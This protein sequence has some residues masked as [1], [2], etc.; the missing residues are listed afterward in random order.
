MLILSVFITCMVITAMITDITRF[1]IPNLLVV[2]IL[3]TYPTLLFLAPVMPDWQIALLIGLATFFVGFVLFAL[4]I[5][6][7]GDVKLLAVMAIFVSKSA[8]IQ[9]LMLIAISGGALSVLLLVSRPMAAYSFSKLGKNA[10]SIPRILTTD[11]PVPYGVAIG[12]SFL[13]LLWSGQI[14][15]IIL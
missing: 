3:L 10:A 6:G 1:I 4:K 14:P 9:F 7:G 13:I 2:I 8:F 12:L 11:E 15:G 5:M